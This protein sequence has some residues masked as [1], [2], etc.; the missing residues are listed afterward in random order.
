MLD[1]PVP[2]LTVLLWTAAAWALALVLLLVL[3][4]RLPDG[5][6]KDLV[7]FAPAC[8][9][10]CRAL[11]RDPAVPRRAKVALGFALLWVLSPVD[12][13][14]EFLPVVGL[15]D[16]VLVVALVLRWAGRQVPREVLLAA[17]PGETRLLE[18]LLGT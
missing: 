2:W 6:L 10:A 15:L 7:G 11:R 13:V 12:L 9:A 18:R 5:V 1:E 3:A 16:D 14:P 17:W 4:K 8:A